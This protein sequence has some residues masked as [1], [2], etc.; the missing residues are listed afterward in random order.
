MVRIE[1]TAVA[2][3]ALCHGVPEDRLLEAQGS[4]GGGFYLCVL[5][6][7][8]SYRGPTESYSDVILRLRLARED[9]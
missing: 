3:A 4:P 8:R 2:Y 7:L 6:R 1:I 5:D 9:A